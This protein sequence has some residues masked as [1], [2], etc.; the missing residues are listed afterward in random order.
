[1]PILVMALALLLPVARRLKEGPWPSL[2]KQVAM[3]VFVVAIAATCGNPHFSSYFPGSRQSWRNVADR[4]PIV[5]SPLREL[6]KQYNVDLADPIVCNYEKRSLLVAWTVA[7]DEEPAMMN[8]RSWL[9]KPILML[10]G[11]P[12]E[13][14]EAY[15]QRYCERARQG[16]WFLMYKG[17]AIDGWLLQQIR[18]THEVKMAGECSNYRLYWC[19]YK[20]ALASPSP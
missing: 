7:S 10:K 20:K 16:G 2:L 18:R 4:L 1:M 5:K 14:R 11:L 17:S 8:S 6:V 19:E 9:P 13:R 3:P 12:P 15:I